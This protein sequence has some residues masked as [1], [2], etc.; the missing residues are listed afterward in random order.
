MV[1]DAAYAYAQDKLMPRVTDAFRHER[2]TAIFRE[3]GEL[4]RSVRLCRPSSAVP[5]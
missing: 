2:L 1:R 4:G 3:M 5:R